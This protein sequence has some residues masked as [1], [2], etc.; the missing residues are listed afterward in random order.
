MIPE[1]LAKSI[2]YT[3]LTPVATL[4]DV[5]KVCEEGKKYNFASVVVN[6]CYVDLSQRLLKDSPVKV[7]TVV[8]FPFGATTPEVKR[9]EAEN[10]IERGAR[11]IDM[12]LNVGVLK[13]GDLEEVYHDIQGVVD[14]TRRKEVQVSG[15]I[16]V[17]VIIETGYLENFEKKAACRLV[18][19][20]GADFVKTGTG[21]GPAGANLEDVK[22]LRECLTP[23][24]GIKA[25]GG[26]KTLDQAVDLIQN[27]ASRIGTSSGVE[28]MEEFFAK[29]R[30]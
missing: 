6:P 29:S 8:G 26:I 5:E 30:K 15:S 9:F 13:S 20:A 22:F 2:D 28:I 12:V 11:E 25:S 19:E 16:I 23:E 14:L 1:E 7:G 27:G 24:V 21:F 18:E 3:L 17:K 10:A 4:R